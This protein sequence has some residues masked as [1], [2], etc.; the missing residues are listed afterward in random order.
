MQK[1][2]L[3]VIG[4]HCGGCAQTVARFLE[5]KQCQAVL[6][7]HANNH[8]EFSSGDPDQLPELIKGI[9]SLG[10]KVNLEQA[11]VQESI[12]SS[13]E[14]KFVFSLIFTI[15]LILHMFVDWHY[16]HNSQIQ[17]LLCLPVYILGFIHFGNSAWGSIKNK[18]PNMDVLIF[19]GISASFI[20]SLIG[21][22]Q[23]LGA[24]F[25]FYETCASI[26]T[27]VLLGN[28][29]E[30]RSVKY[31]TTAI[32]ALSKMRPE[33]AKRKTIGKQF[34]E[35]AAKEI[36]QNDILLCNTG[37]KIPCD[38]EIIQGQADVD[39]AMISGESVPVS[40]EV[41]NKVI[42]GTIVVSGNIQ[43]RATAIGEQT[44]LAKIIG[45]VKAARASKPK[46]QRL[47]DKVSMYFTPIVISIA[48]L[49]FILAYFI[50][51]LSFQ[52]SMLQAIAVLVVACPC[53]M[54]IA[55][56]TAVVVGLGQAAKSGV[57][58]KKADV[59][60]RLSGLTTIVFDKTGTLTNGKFLIESEY[61]N[62]IDKDYAKSILLS[63]ESF[64]SHPIA[65]SIVEQLS[66]YKQLNMLDVVEVKG[67]GISAK[68][69]QG[70]FYSINGRNTKNNRQFDLNLYRNQEL[71]AGF[72]INDQLKPECIEVIS[73]LK[74]LGIKPIL[75]SG[76]QKIKT[77]KV[78]NELGIEEFYFEK[79]PEEKLEIIAKL[80]QDKKSPNEK[81]AMLGDGIND[82]AALAKA[83]IGIS[84]G[85]ATA[86][87]IESAEI[88]LLNDHLNS[89]LKALEISKLTLRTIKQNLFWAFF[90]N[91]A[92]IPFAASGHLSPILAAGAMAF[93]DFIVV[94][95][96]LRLKLRKI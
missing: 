50:F 87:A 32:E 80:C 91:V 49:T 86:V 69:S 74:K 19:V 4:M 22:I 82:A 14:F 65:K 67:T 7:E 78:A 18:Q 77:E 3:Q 70:N 60:E 10:Y 61:F 85:A 33:R 72:N 79:H 35:I 94:L 83:D 13:I 34:V 24:N 38:G 81:I 96:S 45:L 52:Q 8:V 92:S 9:E 63:I 16:L 23:N 93:S 75:L 68:D 95:N 73:Q 90:Y 42:G 41:G 44:I 6:V 31:T 15:P 53:A 37:D 84:L 59:F 57:L 36:Q 64:S 11:K 56:P 40:K 39:Q 2:E 76:D 88:I 17:L 71:V 30:H 29:I 25:L 43:V 28:L 21:T 48:L 66:A 46:L 1:Y 12:F 47:G 5:S 62:N 55:T 51:S 89:L 26:I 58:I 20:Y 27:L 54:G